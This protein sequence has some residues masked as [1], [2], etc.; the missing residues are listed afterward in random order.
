MKSMSLVFAAVWTIL[1]SCNSPEKHVWNEIRIDSIQEPIIYIKNDY[2]GWRIDES[3]NQTSDQVITALANYQRKCIILELDKN[4]NC[5][6]DELVHIALTAKRNGNN[7]I[8]YRR[9]RGAIDS[10]D[11][12][13]EFIN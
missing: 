1:Q 6:N 11:S 10:I 9:A 4:S 8:F 7:R 5:E 2:N 3:I 12:V 13:Y